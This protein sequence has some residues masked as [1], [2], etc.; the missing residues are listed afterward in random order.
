M[1]KSIK[2]VSVKNLVAVAPVTT[3]AS[4]EAYDKAIAKASKAKPTAKP[5]QVHHFAPDGVTRVSS[6]MDSS[7]K[8]ANSQAHE[9]GASLGLTA[10]LG[11]SIRKTM[12]ALWASPIVG[13]ETSPIKVFKLLQNLGYV[14]ETEGASGNEGSPHREYN[15]KTFGTAFHPIY[16]QLCAT[17]PKAVEL[18][19]VAAVKREAKKTTVAPK[20]TES[21]TKGLTTPA[22]VTD[23][24]VKATCTKF[25]EMHPTAT[26][27]VA[28]L[29]IVAATLGFKLEGFKSTDA[30]L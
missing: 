1:T 27:R 2:S 7:L 24:H 13:A 17:A 11:E 15:L 30:P 21:E 19:K 23:V 16:K 9:L 6:V 14:P 22:V 5:K 4:V 18:A 20:V 12:A 29:K 28:L 26:Q 3:V 8:L 10:R 25:M